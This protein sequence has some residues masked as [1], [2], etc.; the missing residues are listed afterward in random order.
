MALHGESE[1]AL[2]Q[3]RTTLL[4]IAAA[5]LLVALKLG[6]GL[7]TSS[8][9]L[10][11]AGIESSGDVVAA[12]VTFF[13][14]RLGGRPADTEHPY[15]H[16]RAE[17]LG[18]LGEAT[19]LLAGGAVVALEAT[20]HLI[21]SA[22]APDIHWYQFAVIGA[23]LVVDLSRTVVSLRTARRFRSAALRSNAFHFAGDMAGS[24][25]LLVGLLAGPAPRAPGGP[26]P[27]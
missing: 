2:T 5:A 27:R 22:T 8:L 6:V 23:A 1:Q 25:A 15:G 9:G 20:R 26:Y 12:I 14:V 3:Q 10:V 7:A 4:S 19:I 24:G 11:S 21:E 18:A 17:N 13:A 16:R